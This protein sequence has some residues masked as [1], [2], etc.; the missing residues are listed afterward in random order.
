MFPWKSVWRVVSVLVSLV[1]VRPKKKTIIP[2]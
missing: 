2:T 1:Y